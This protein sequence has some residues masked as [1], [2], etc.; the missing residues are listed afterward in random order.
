M[1]EKKLLST[2]E[3]AEILGV[4]HSTLWN[5]INQGLLPAV[6]VGNS[7]VVHPDDLARFEKPKM[8]RPRNDPEI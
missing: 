2:A 8:G 1:A 7:W 6:K 3:A 5:Y 4:A